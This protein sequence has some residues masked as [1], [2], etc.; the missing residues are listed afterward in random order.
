MALGASTASSV[1]AALLALEKP[2]E[3]LGPT[4]YPFPRECPLSKH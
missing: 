4:I 3:D 1:D 2:S